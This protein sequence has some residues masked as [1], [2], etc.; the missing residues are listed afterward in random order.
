M[1]DVAGLTRRYGE[2]VAV[3][4]VPLRLAGWARGRPV[5]LD[6]RVP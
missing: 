6:F 5:R 2:T 1:I 3:A 4:D